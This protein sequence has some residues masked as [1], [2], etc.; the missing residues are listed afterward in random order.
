MVLGASALLGR[1]CVA[2]KALCFKQECIR[3]ALHTTPREWVL[4]SD[5]SGAGQGA[6]RTEATR[7]SGRGC[8]S[9]SVVCKPHGTHCTSSAGPALNFHN[10]ARHWQKLA[11]F[12]N[13]FKLSYTVWKRRCLPLNQSTGMVQRSAWLWCTLVKGPTCFSG[14][15]V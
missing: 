11:P 14:G 6:D 10:S 3:S 13:I 2:C 7:L 12:L 1:R 9:A 4:T 15:S 5:A 8:A